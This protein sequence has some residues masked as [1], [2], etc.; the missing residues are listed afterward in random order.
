MIVFKLAIS[1][2]MCSHRMSSGMSEQ[3]HLV[4]LGIQPVELRQWTPTSN[5]LV[6]IGHLV[7]PPRNWDSF[8]VNI[9]WGIHTVR[10][11]GMRYHTFLLAAA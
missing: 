3:V 10:L 11:L 9:G 6:R 8:L 5:M 4:V 1:L 2:F 7:F